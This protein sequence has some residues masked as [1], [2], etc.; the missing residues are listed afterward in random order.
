M[1]HRLLSAA[2]ILLVGCGVVLAVG[3]LEQAAAPIAQLP[4]LLPEGAL[5]SIEARDFSSLLKDW[6]TSPEKRTWLLSDNYAE[7]SNSRLF[8]RLSQAKD[9]FSAAAGL[10]T[11]AS[12]LEKVAGKE[13]CL[14]LYD[15]GNL[16][17]V[18]VTRLDQQ[19]IENTPLWQTRSKFEQRTEAGTAFYVHKDAQSSRIAAFASKD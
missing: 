2:A 19:D 8:S 3:Q 14:G 15:I 5:L 9:E 11:D 10:P 17:F 13:S 4:A 18:Y 16:E 7:F 6:N 1:K 12:L